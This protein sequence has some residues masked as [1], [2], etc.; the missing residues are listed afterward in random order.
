MQPTHDATASTGKRPFVDFYA[1]HAISPVAQD[2]TDIKNHFA[3]RAALYHHLGL[4]PALLSGARLAEFGPGSGHNALYT[5]SLTPSRY[6]LVDANPTGLAETGKNLSKYFPG[7]SNYEIVRSMIQEFQSEETFD[8]VFCEGV[9]PSQE[10]PPAFLRHVA[11]FVRPGGIMV[12]TCMD[13]VSALA[14]IMRRL[15]G[16]A[17]ID[18]D[19]PVETK[20]ELLRP[21]CH[22]QTATLTNMT[23]PL[24]DWILDMV[25]RPAANWGSLMSI[26]E[27]IK[28]LS[29]NFQACQSSPRIFT[30]L[31]WYKNIP[32]DSKSH[33]DLAIDAFNRSMHQFLDCRY[34]FAEQPV[35]SNLKI[36]NLCRT[37]VDNIFAYE[38]ENKN[39][40]RMDKVMKDIRALSGIVRTFSPETAGSL[41]DFVAAFETL[42]STGQFS[43]QGIHFDKVLSI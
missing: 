20:L 29:Q 32:R 17:I 2:L 13:S 38:A 19:S 34:E 33:N 10:D 22:A 24:D 36:E 21:V 18:Q 40:A 39:H 28:A 16:V 5:M 15:I 6:L 1:A 42:A 4:A 25:I 14:D 12:T 9:I 43:E 31:R 23:R 7:H 37:I 26:S 30:D 35:A 27:A 11:Q 3:N 41:D 8:V